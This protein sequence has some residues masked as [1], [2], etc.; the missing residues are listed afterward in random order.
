MGRYAYSASRVDTT[1]DTDLIII[2][3]FKMYAIGRT[4]ADTMCFDAF[5][6]RQ[7]TVAWNNILVDLTS[8]HGQ[9][10]VKV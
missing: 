5:F 7:N 3:T 6:L 1:Q 8:T 10:V 9:E 2:M 4:I